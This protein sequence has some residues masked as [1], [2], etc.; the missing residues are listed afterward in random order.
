MTAI[1]KD[2]EAADHKRNINRNRK[3][4]KDA[5]IITIPPKR[6]AILIIRPRRFTMD[7]TIAEET[8]LPRIEIIYRT[9]GEQTDEEQAQTNTEEDTNMEID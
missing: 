6:R 5:G 8:Q 9:V 2:E 4:K 3:R 7:A 1:R